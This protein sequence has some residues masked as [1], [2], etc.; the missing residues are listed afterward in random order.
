MQAGKPNRDYTHYGDYRVML[1]R[2]SK[3]WI[4]SKLLEELF[5]HI[6]QLS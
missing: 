5:C 4:I 6:F 2:E 1:E 3:W